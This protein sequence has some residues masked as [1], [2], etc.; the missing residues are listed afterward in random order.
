ME[1]WENS[2]SSEQA[3]AENPGEQVQGSSKHSGY[4]HRSKRPSERAM[5]LLV[6]SWLWAEY[7]P[8]YCRSLAL[9]RI[10]RHCY[11]IDALGIGSGNAPSL[12]LSSEQSVDRSVHQTDA[13][14][15]SVITLH[16]LL[17]TGRASKRKA[18]EQPKS[19]PDSKPAS[20]RKNSISTPAVEIIPAH[21]RESAAEILPTIEQS[22]AIFLLNPCVPQ[23]FTQDDLR[24][25]FQRSM[26]GEYCFVLWHKQVEQCLK[27][28]HKRQE[29]AATLTALLRSD[30]WKNLRADKAEDIQ[31]FI[32]LF[33]RAI[34][35][36]FPWPPQQ[37][38]LQHQIGAASIAPLPM[39]ILFATRRPDS[40]LSMNDAHCHYQRETEQAS[41]KGILSEEWFIQQ[42][43]QR[44]NS[45]LQQ[46]QQQLQQQGTSRKIRHWPELRQYSILQNFGY[47]TQTEYDTCI[48]QLI[49]LRQVR[50]LWRQPAPKQQGPEQSTIRT[51]GN[52]D[53]LL[54]N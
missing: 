22:P 47:Y 21:W 12:T 28:A 35:R 40:L 7:I 11:I 32:S 51:P 17:L 1:L 42:W 31:G 37:I 14:G 33:A 19:R 48:Q 15:Q 29:Q 10:F 44:H 25:L 16:T 39:T 5:G 6:R 50:C 3:L 46:L 8:A 23:L 2:D 52:E 41:F 36:H 18:T 49:E 34:Q 45:A 13:T 24:A 26:P 43:Q 27:T 9:S 20:Q 38:S 30:R 53:T 4:S 54:W